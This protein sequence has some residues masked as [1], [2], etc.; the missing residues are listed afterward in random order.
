MAIDPEIAALVE[1][2]NQAPAIDYAADPL[3]TARQLRAATAVR[4]P[5]NRVRTEDRNIAGSAGDIR[6]RLYRPDGRGPFPL[7]LNLH[8]GGWVRGSI[9]LEDFLCHELAEAVNCV[10]ASVDYRL[11]PENRYPAALDDAYAALEWIAEE[12]GALGAD[13]GRIAVMG[14][15]SGGNLAA[16]LALL[17]RDRAGPRLCQQLL[18]YPVC[19]ADFTRPSFSANGTGFGLTTDRMRWFW[20][21][22]VPDPKQRADPYASPLR[23][24]DLSRLPPALVVTAEHDPLRDEG[25]LYA[26]RLAQ[27][28]VKARLLRSPG[29]IHGFAHMAPQARESRRAVAECVLTLTKAFGGA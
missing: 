2:I 10:V 19:D 16:S 11:A 26:E 27:A 14:S 29:M 17:T 7:L 12:A 8:G 24:P 5:A 28:G 9:E 21:Q 18:L 4:A 3:E 13:A 15:S 23:A 25:E 1:Q 6:L 22:Y 20:D